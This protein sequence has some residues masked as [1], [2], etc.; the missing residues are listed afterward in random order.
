M[1]ASSVSGI[2]VLE[3]LVVL[4]PHSYSFVCLSLLIVSV[5]ASCTF[6]SLYLL[7]KFITSSVILPSC[8]VFCS[9]FVL[10]P[11]FYLVVHIAL[12]ALLKFLPNI[13]AHYLLSNSLDHFS[14]NVS[15]VGF[16]NV[17]LI[18]CLLVGVC[19]CV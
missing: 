14:L 15:L 16:V 11:K 10:C 17:V 8:N 9:Y 18:D 2:R 19:M 4:Q 12:P 7:S 1:S 3:S 13:F 6:E 5:F